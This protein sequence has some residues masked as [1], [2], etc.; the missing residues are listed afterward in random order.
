M[1]R[2]V[3]RPALVQHVADRYLG[4]GF[5]HQPSGC[6]ADSSRSAGDEG[7]FAI[8]TVHRVCS[9]RWAIILSA[10][11]AQRQPKTETDQD[12]SRTQR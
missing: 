4:A 2:V 5:D 3:S 10:A 9:L 11:A 12:R 7:D 8:E 6:G 1:D